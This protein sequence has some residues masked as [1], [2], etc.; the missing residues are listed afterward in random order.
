[1][2]V[3][4]VSQSNIRITPTATLLDFTQKRIILGQMRYVK[5]QIIR[6]SA[7]SSLSVVGLGCILGVS[8]F[9][10]GPSLLLPIVMPVMYRM[11]SNCQNLP[12]GSGTEKQ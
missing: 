9:F 1:M 3:E 5:A 11:W 8:G 4:H 12:T 6:S 2:G 10:M 7:Y